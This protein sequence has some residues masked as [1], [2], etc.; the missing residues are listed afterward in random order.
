MALQ[1][2]HLSLRLHDEIVRAL[3]ST[4]YMYANESDLG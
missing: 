3:F 2:P 4:G 1:L